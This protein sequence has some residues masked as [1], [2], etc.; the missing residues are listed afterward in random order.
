MKNTLKYVIKI[1]LIV[2]NYYFCSVISEKYQE[3]KKLP[4]T[5]LQKIGHLTFNCKYNIF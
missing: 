4:V 1:Q 5:I 2:T 3:I